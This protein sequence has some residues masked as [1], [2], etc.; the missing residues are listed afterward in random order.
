MSKYD[1]MPPTTAQEAFARLDALLDEE[2][3]KRLVEDE[4]AIFNAHFTLGMWIRNNWSY[5]LNDEERRSFLKMF[6]DDGD[7][8][9]FTLS[10]EIS[11]TIINKYVEY[12]KNKS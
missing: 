4:M 3:K 5:P 8:Y 12:L 9:F 11:S 10:D 2:D 1:E 7:E 6:E